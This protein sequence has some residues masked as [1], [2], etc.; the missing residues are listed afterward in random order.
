MFLRTNL[1]SSS[2][3][4]VFT[5]RALAWQF[6]NLFILHLNSIS[7]SS[8][9]VQTWISLWSGTQF[10]AEMWLVHRCHFDMSPIL[11]LDCRNWA[12]SKEGETILFSGL[13]FF[14][15]ILLTKDNIKQ[16]YFP[17]ITQFKEG[18]NISSDCLIICLVSWQSYTWGQ[19]L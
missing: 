16:P 19:K 3:L 9:N 4:I 11:C 6:G 10:W 17:S 12:Q 7:T 14:M 5:A 15:F 13:F 2:S 18:Y 8:C 1:L